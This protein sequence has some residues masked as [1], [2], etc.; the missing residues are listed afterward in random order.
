MDAIAFWS[1]K[2]LLRVISILSGVSSR[3]SEA[4][5]N[6]YVEFDDLALVSR[7]KTNKYKVF[8]AIIGRGKRCIEGIK[9]WINLEKLQVLMDITALF[10]LPP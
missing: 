3:I 4:C 7:H 5:Q 1:G 2:S 6:G 10:V 8:E 9:R